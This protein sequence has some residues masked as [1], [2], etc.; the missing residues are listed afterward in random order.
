MGCHAFLQGIFLTQGLNPCLLCLLHWQAGS[1]TTSATWEA[2]AN[3]NNATINIDANSFKN[4]SFNYF[5][6]I[7]SGSYGNSIFNFWRN[8]HTVF[9]SRRT[10]F[11]FLPIVQKH[12]NL[13]TSVSTLA[14]FSL[15]GSSHPNGC[16]VVSHCSFDFHFL[17]D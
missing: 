11:P 9:H 8:F 1:L 12:S 2:P 17:N 10:I 7:P 5:G 15:V 16:E 14:I 3:V 6:C 4:P 13:S